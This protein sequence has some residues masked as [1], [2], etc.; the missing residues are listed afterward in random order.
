MHFWRF[1][2][3]F[4]LCFSRR[5]V[6]ATSRNSAYEAGMR[7]GLG[8]GAGR[9]RVT[10][11]RGAGLLAVLV[12][13]RFCFLALIFPTWTPRDSSVHAQGAVEWRKQLSSS[14]SHP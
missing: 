4:R 6:D 2:G 9:V 5:S 11:L 12:T 3:V 7:T 13:H 14:H 1:L 8:T 10:V